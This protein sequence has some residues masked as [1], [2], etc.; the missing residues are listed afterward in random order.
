MKKRGAIVLAGGR[1][2]RMGRD[3]WMLPIGTQTVLERLVDRLAPIVD[4]RVTIVAAAGGGPLP[5]SLCADERVRITHD[6]ETGVGPLAGLRAGLSAGC[7]ELYVVAAAD[8]PFFTGA[9]ADRLLSELGRS[10]LEC[11]VPQRQGKLHPL[12]AAYHRRSLPALESCLATGGRKVMEWVR[13]LAWAKMPEEE[14]DRVD[15]EGAAFY[16]M[17]TME[18]YEAA[19]RLYHN[20]S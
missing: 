14:L 9:V 2:T 10:G 3:K 17:N 11:V 6:A 4:D 1:S 20:K 8:M 16:N 15:P 19:L 7:A 13:A 18:D 5:A 12:A